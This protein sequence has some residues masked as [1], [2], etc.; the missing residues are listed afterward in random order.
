MA[1]ELVIVLSYFGIAFIFAVCVFAYQCYEY[2]KSRTMLKWGYWYDSE[3]VCA[4]FMA[5]LFF[6]IAIIVGICYIPFWLIKKRF[7]VEK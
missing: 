2:K 1:K 5:S 6:P 4:L 7:N 3:K